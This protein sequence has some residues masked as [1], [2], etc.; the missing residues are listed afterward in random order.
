[1]QP[2]VSLGSGALIAVLRPIAPAP[3]ADAGL[4]VDRVRFSLGALFVPT[5]RL[6]LA[7]GS[8]HTWLLS[9]SARACYAP[10]RSGSIRL[11]VCSGF[12]LGVIKG[13]AHGFTRTEAHTRVFSALPIEIALAQLG[14]ALG[15]E[16][17]AAL[18]VPF[19][20]NQFAVENAGIAY[21]SPPVAAL[22]TL[23]GVVLWPW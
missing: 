12:A 11:D 16:F 17:G 18:L 13:S 21:D 3:L 10:L 2:S 1:V 23:R 4:V 9:A 22:V 6:E 14:R 8:V 7:P 15:W 20:R 19:R 5:Q